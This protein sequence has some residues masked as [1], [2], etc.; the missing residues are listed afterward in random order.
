[1]A[2]WFPYQDLD[3]L[4]GAMSAGYQQYNVGVNAGAGGSWTLPDPANS[5]ITNGWHLWIRDKGSIK[6]ED[7]GL[8]ISDPNGFSI[9]G[10]P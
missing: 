4:T 10:L 6:I 1:M 3:T 5:E 8:T 2:I 7:G 9:N